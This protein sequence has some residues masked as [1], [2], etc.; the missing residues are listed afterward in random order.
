MNNIPNFSQI[1]RC[2]TGS[3][4]RNVAGICDTV[5]LTPSCAV[6]GICN[7]PAG[8][9]CLS[10]TTYSPCSGGT[11]VNWPISCS[12]GMI[13]YPTGTNLNPC[14]K[15]TWS[16]TQRCPAGSEPPTTTTTSTAATIMSPQRFCRSNNPGYYRNPNDV[17]CRT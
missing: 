10:Q 15:M 9:A 12:N 8:Y 6:C 4:C 14:T 2:P 11:N 7:S 13:C 16:Q 3:V 17:S 5:T 1:L